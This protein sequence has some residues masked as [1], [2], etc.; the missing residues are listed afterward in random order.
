MS[1]A[2]PAGRGPPPAGKAPRGNRG[3]PIVRS[4]V[5]E[6]AKMQAHVRDGTF[7]KPSRKSPFVEAIFRLL[8]ADRPEDRRD[9]RNRS[10]RRREART[11]PHRARHREGHPPLGR[12][13]ATAQAITDLD[14]V[15]PRQWRPATISSVTLSPCW[16]VKNA[17]HLPL[18]A[19]GVLVPR[20]P[21]TVASPSDTWNPVI[22]LSPLFWNPPPRLWRPASIVA[23]G[24][25]PWARN[26]SGWFAGSE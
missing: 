21:L 3:P 16:F 10:R 11:R 14:R 19:F 2:R 15:R 17:R 1:G 26:R 13:C 25:R 22:A 5:T 23:D 9:A 4:V 24:S 20:T 6:R 7:C 8:G 18:S 12:G